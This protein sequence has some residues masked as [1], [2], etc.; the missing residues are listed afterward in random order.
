MNHCEILQALLDKFETEGNTA[1]AAGIRTAMVAAG[2][3]V[4]AESESG[5]SGNGPPGGG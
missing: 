3:G 5:G 4:T 1:A 2:C